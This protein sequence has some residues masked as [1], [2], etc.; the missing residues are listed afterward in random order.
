[1]FELGL[2]SDQSSLKCS[3]INQMLQHASDFGFQIGSIKFDLDKIIQR[4]RNVAKQLSVGIAHL[5]K[6]NNINV[7]EGRGMLLPNKKSVSD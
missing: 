2:Y 6:K 3:E 5:M 4:S 7:I 1:M